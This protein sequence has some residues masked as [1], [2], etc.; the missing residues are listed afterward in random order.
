LIDLPGH[1]ASY[2]RVLNAEP[3]PQI[4][5]GERLPAPRQRVIVSCAVFRCLG[6]IDAER[7]WHFDSTNQEI[8]GVVAWEKFP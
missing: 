8:N 1:A 5:V 2:E 6:Y 3:N 4:P 7:I